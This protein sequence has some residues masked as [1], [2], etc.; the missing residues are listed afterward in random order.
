ML[1]VRTSLLKRSS[2]DAEK[3]SLKNENYSL[4]K[5]SISKSSTNYVF[6]ARI[7]SQLH[8]IFFYRSHTSLY[9]KYLIQAPMFSS[10]YAILFGVGQK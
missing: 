1:N 8:R 2:S 5:R 7:L 10:I 3:K 4:V 6:Q 9:S